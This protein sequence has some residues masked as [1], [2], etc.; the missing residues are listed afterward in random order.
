MTNLTSTQQNLPANIEDL[1]KFVLVGREKLTAVR[2]EIRAIEKIGLAEEVHRQKKDEAK[3]IAALM[4]DAERRLGELMARLPKAT[5]GNQYTGKLV[6]DSA[7]PNQTKE[8]LRFFA[9]NF[10]KAKR[11]T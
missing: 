1:S 6:K 3:A 2:A 11:Q 5:S 8:Q 9:Q 4:L 10:V 7:V